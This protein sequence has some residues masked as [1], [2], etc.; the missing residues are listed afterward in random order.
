MQILSILL[1]IL[2]FGALIFI[3]ELGH[4]IAARLCGVQVL[5]F[6]IGMGPKLISKKSKKSGTAYSIRLFPIGG[7]VSM[8]GENG[9]EAVQGDA[10]N[11][12]LKEADDSASNAADQSAESE[13]QSPTTQVAESD[14]SSANEET[15]L[16]VHAYCNQSV[17][18]RILISLAG[19]AM[20]V[21]LG[22]VL[23]FFMVLLS[24]H[25]ALGTNQIA[26]FYTAYCGEESYEGFQKGDYLYSFDTTESK[27]RI[28]SFAQFKQAVASD[29]DKLYNVYVL[30]YNEETLATE[31]VL[32][33]NITL[34]EEIISNPSYFKMAGSEESGLRV[35]DKVV[36]VNKTS[37]HT[38]NELAYEVM[39]QG[40][41]PMTFTVLRDG[42][43]QEVPISVRQVSEEGIV[44]GELDFI[45][46]REANF[47]VLTILK[48]T[49]FRSCSTVKMVYDSLIGLFT[50]RFGLSAVSGPVG[51]TKTVSEAA[52]MG[53]LNVLYLITVISINLGIMNLLPFPALDGGHLLIYA[54][55][56][57]R[58]KPM[59]KE[60]EGIINFAGL[61][62]LLILAVLVA[63]KDIISL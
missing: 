29:E 63:V 17:W 51:I 36:K 11:D 19:P 52:Q 6:A 3:H 9:M 48:H 2:I 1:A 20:N 5:E 38:Y 58:R 31:T 41:E 27:D 4:F 26:G 15:D 32:L 44:F 16:N 54:I 55:E 40:Y 14:A 33:E 24:G 8:L 18:K 47:N 45:I 50:G 46:Y 42:E 61:V 43:K 59:K 56:V 10:G 23:M 13:E 7:F 25:A 34:S 62:I 30:R 49:W 28:L 53:F 60:L 57:V 22:F 35:N 21:V 12:A 37:I 39:N